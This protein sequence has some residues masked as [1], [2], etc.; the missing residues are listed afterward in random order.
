MDSTV[1][2]AFFSAR[3]RLKQRGGRLELVIPNEATTVQRVVKITALATIMPIHE[4]PSAAL[5]GLRTGEHAIR[6]RDLRKKFG[7]P[8][9]RAAECSCGW[10][11]ETQTGRSAERAARRD[12]K[13]HVDQYR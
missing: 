4:T 7:D 8:E 1:I 6:M 9:A 3:E 12:G 5:A 13:I 11:G 10:V 2:A